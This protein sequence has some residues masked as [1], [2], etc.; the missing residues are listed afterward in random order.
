MPVDVKLFECV[1]GQC[2]LK[3][4]KYLGGGGGGGGG[5]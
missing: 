3:I 1:K 5:G 4:V 2:G